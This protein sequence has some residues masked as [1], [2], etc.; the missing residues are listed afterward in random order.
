MAGEPPDLRQL[1]F[2][3][4][5]EGE[6]IELTPEGFE[7]LEFVLVAGRRGLRKGQEMV[8]GGLRPI[9]NMMKT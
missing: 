2:D 5:G 1:G 7:A 9:V 4:R 6:R 8:Q 3:D